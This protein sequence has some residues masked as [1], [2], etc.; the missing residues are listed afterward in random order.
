M[1]IRYKNDENIINIVLCMSSDIM[2]WRI[3][4]SVII[5]EQDFTH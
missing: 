2:R 4:L 5:I 1:K 3:T